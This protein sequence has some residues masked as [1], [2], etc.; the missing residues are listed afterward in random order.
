MKRPKLVNATT[1]QLEEL[2]ALAKTSFA[3]R[4]YELLESPAQ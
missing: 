2:W 4:Q 3:L 1:A